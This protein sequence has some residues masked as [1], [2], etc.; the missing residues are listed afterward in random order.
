MY[1][2]LSKFLPPFKNHVIPILSHD[3]SSS[4]V[5]K[6][7]VYQLPWVNGGPILRKGKV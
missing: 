5:L 1:N 2:I 4:L 7:K 3:I 6:L